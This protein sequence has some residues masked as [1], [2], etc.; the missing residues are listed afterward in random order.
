[1]FTVLVTGAS[2][3]IGR[4]ICSGLLKKG[5]E[6]LAIDS[7][8]NDYNK[9]KPHYQFIEMEIT[10]KMGYGE[11]F[12][13]YRVDVLIHAACTVDNDLGHII[14]E[15][16]MKLSASVDKYVY[17]YAMEAGVKEIIMLSTYQVYDFP[18][19]REPIRED[20]D[21]RLFTNYAIMKYESEKSFVLEMTHHKH[22]I[23]CVLRFAPVYTLKFYDNL[24]SKI[25]DPKD[26]SNFVY[27]TGQYGFQFCCVHNLV[28][29]ILCFVN[30]A[31]DLTYSGVYNVSDKTLIT[32]SEIIAFMREHYRLGPVTQRSAGK[33][34]ITGIFKRFSKNKEEK[35]NYR[36][37][38][39]S[40]IE[41]NN[42]LDNT[43]ASKLLSFRWNI[44]NTK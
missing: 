19:T 13:D 5:Y 26:G 37:L 7:T 27:G 29:F 11:I 15:K 25:K 16:E 35:T 30:N 41:N 20:D 44:H 1:M 23:C 8:E 28:D 32:A 12:D 38:D 2:G 24:I 17:R 21:I 10:D 39:V 18:K 6:V 9:G 22:V 31:E 33:D 4:H 42:M 43:R 40:A 3:L 34:S 36:Y 14:T